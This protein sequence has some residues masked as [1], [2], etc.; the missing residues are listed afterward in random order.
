MPQRHVQR[1]VVLGAWMCALAL[2][3]VLS[4]GF[5]HHHEL[6][7]AESTCQLCVLISTASGD[8]LPPSAGGVASVFGWEVLIVP[9]GRAPASIAVS[10]HGA[11]GPPRG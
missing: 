7:A 2:G 8:G 10:E 4:S 5:W 9:M 1:W 3:L 11:R 6:G